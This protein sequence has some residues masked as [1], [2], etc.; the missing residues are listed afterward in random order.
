MDTYFGYKTINKSKGMIKI[1]TLVKCFWDRQ[2][3]KITGKGNIDGH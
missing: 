2:G 1:I 3:G